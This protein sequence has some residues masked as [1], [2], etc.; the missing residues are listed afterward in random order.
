MHW[1]L[2]H[3]CNIVRSARIRVWCNHKNLTFGSTKAHQSKRVLHYKIDI[4][5]D[6]N[7]EILHINGKMNAGRDGMSRLPTKAVTE[8]EREDLLTT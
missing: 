8:K 2:Q 7:D 4:S 5:N 1:G 3:F 6:Y